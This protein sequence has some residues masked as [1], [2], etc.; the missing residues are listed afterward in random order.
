MPD[1][2]P[3]APVPRRRLE[4]L[5]PTFTA[6][7]ARA[8]GI[9]PRDL[10]RLRDD[11]I[12]Y[13][14]S[15]GVF[16]KANAPESAHLDLLAVAAR[17]PGAVI[18]GETALSLHELIDDIPAQ[19]TIAVARGTHR[20]AIDYPPVS[21]SQYEADTF[22]AGIEQFEAAPGEYV[23]VYGAARSVADAMRLRHRT[24]ET[25][26]LSALG[27]YVRLHG[28]AGV[29]DLLKFSRLLGVQGPVRSAIEAV[30]A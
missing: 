7:S 11:E 10:Y 5:P 6:A 13:E 24:G 8:A 27:R 21:V 17:A 18:C 25:Q 14:L 1:A 19:V 4:P 22:K 12:I 9:A 30:L 26:A 15:R 23:P 29:A 16:R 20:P 28:P 3:S 2:S